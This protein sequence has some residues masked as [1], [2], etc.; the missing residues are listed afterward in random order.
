MREKNEG[1][2]TKPKLLNLCAALSQ[3]E[4][5][6]RQKSHFPSKNFFLQSII[7]PSEKKNS[8]EQVA[9]RHEVKVVCFLPIPFLYYQLFYAKRP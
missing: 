8:L 5:I 7:Y 6:K 9:F 1:L 3:Y 2:Q 4:I